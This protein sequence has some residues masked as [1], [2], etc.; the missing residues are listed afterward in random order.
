MNSTRLNKSIL[1]VAGI[2]M[3]VVGFGILFVPFSF[4]AGVGLMLDHDAVL[5]NELRSPGGALLV[6][7]V[8]VVVGAFRAGLGY[9]AMMLAFVV[10]MSY[11]LSRIVSFALDG[12]PGA[13]LM[14][15]TVL[16]IVMGLI[17]GF[18]LWQNRAKRSAIAQ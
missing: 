15:V 11:G 17:C 8:V 13:G 9:P 16:E 3:L 7:G 10:Y 6:A 4:H 2:I 18:A 14:Q 5:L 12:L 1:I